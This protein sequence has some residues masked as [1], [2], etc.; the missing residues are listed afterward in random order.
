M[1]LSLIDDLVDWPAQLRWPWWAKVTALAGCVLLVPALLFGFWGRGVLDSISSEEARY[2]EL[3]QRWQTQSAEADSQAALQARVARLEADL[4]HSQR[5]LFDADG[6]ASLLQSLGQL[7]RGLSFEEVLVQ[8]PEA[9]ANY[10]ELPLQLRAL[11]EYR[12]LESFIAG[13]AGLGQLVTVHELQLTA[14]DAGGPG[15]MHVQMRLHAYRVL[16][17]EAVVELATQAST[18]VR[19]PF[20]TTEAWGTG[21]EAWGLEQARMV[22]YLRDRH[23]QAALVRLG[24]SVY[25]LRAGD[26]LA[27]ARVM[28]VEEGRIELLGMAEGVAGIPRVLTLGKG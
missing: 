6:L 15:L 22:G 5:E 24:D 12:A 27:D 20:E 26:L 10:V 28:L 13:L 4:L 3:Q 17:P 18:A 1:N 7:G 21:G 25:L 19:N 11:G 23:G 14:Q 8:D 16:Q 2:H 9:R